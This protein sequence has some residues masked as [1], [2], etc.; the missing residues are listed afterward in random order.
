MYTKQ[1]FDFK[2]KI[3]RKFLTSIPL[4]GVS[5]YSTHFERV[6]GQGG[7]N[8]LVVYVP[9]KEPD[10]NKDYLAKILHAVG[11]RLEEDAFYLAAKP[12]E[13]LNWAGIK[14]QFPIKYCL[15]FGIDPAKAGIRLV[16]GS[17]RPKIYQ[18]IGYLCAESLE[19]I[20]LEREAGDNRA[21]G[22]LWKALLELFPKA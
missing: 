8:L 16:L 13:N 5:G 12:D 9:G 19:K 10:A 18:G 2:I 4:F 1:L 14:K 3:L 17:Y 15:L 22:I 21:A 6:K 7:K 11:I 20:R